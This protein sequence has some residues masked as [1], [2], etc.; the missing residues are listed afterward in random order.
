MVVRVAYFPQDLAVPVCFQ[1]DSAFERKATEKALLRCA[2]VVEERPAVGEVAGQARRVGHVPGV[3]DV[4][5]KVDEI[6]TS[7]APDKRSK[8][9]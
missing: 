2:A 6:D 4:A 7:I 1:D 8:E 3:D 5:V 9:R